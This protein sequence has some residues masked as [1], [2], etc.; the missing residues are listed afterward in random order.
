MAC[1]PNSYSILAWLA[2]HELLKSSAT[3][4][5]G[6]DLVLFRPSH[7]TG[8]HTP[9]VT[10]RGLSCQAPSFSWSQQKQRKNGHYVICTSQSLVELFWLLSLSVPNMRHLSL[11]GMEEQSHFSSFA[12]FISRYVLFISGSL[13]VSLI[14]SVRSFIPKTSSTGLQMNLTCSCGVCYAWSSC[15]YMGAAL[16]FARACV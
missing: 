11:G 2:Q 7:S 5:K 15:V 14:Y 8:Y 13:S 10:P 6:K 12:F 4:E 16:K 1:Y 9:L 3:S